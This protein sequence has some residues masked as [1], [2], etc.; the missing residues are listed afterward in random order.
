[1]K[2]IFLQLAG[3]NVWANESLLKVLS[4]L[5]E[6]KLEENF[7]SSFSTITK[8]VLHMYDAEMIW[9]QRLKLR[10]KPVVPSESF[11]GNFAELAQLVLTQNR[12]WMQWIQ[13]AQEHMLLHEFIYHNSKREQFK[14]PVYQ[15]LLQVFNH[16]T[17]HR[18]Q[19]V[20]MLRQAGM[21]KIPQTDFIVYSRK[22]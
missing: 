4:Q 9:W 7:A 11:T 18:G 17:Y 21:E 19:L 20:N 14:Q 12:Q 15:V 5:P 1:M 8:T 16:G 13:Q 2:A 10:E 3:F 22:K 6:S